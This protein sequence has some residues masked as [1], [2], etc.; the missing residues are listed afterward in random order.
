M[1]KD[2]YVLWFSIPIIVLSFLA[3]FFG[4]FYS[5]TVYVQEVISYKT[6]AIGQDLVTLIIVLPTFIISMYF[7]YHKKVIGILFWAGCLFYF[8]YTYIVYSFGLHFNRLF[9]VYCSLLGLSVYGFMYFLLHYANTIIIKNV[10]INYVAIYLYIIAGVFYLLWFSE[11]VPAMIM[12]TIPKSVIEAQ[13]MTNSVHVADISL[14]LPFLIITGVLIQNK[15]MLG[16]VFS[17]V[18]LF[19]SILL[20]LAVLGMIIVMTINGVEIEIALTAIFLVI[21]IISLLLLVNTAVKFK[22]VSC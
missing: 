9:L 8:L 19:F 16:Y 17:L 5:D 1:E 4:V 11:E 22:K 7:A 10:R 15:K 12:N 20:S 18:A 21:S 2:K 6:Q 3:C 13:I 14:C